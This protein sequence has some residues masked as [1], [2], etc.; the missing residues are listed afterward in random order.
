MT[1]KEYIQG[2]FKSFGISL[3]E[4]DLFEMCANL[5]SGDEMTNEELIP[6]KVAICRFIP[7]LLV[8]PTAISEAGFS[9]SWNKEGVKEYYAILCKELGL[10]NELKP[11]VT[12]G[13]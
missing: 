2:R 6:A 8:R 3:S 12:F 13:R 11:K 7:S 9:L 1:V 5:K 10:K 4:A